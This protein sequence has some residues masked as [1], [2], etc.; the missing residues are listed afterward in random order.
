MKFTM[1]LVKAGFIEKVSLVFL[2]KGHTKNNAGKWFNYLKRGTKGK[3]IWDEK[4]LDEA[5][6]SGNEHLIKL[7][8]VP[9]DRWRDFDSW[10]HEYYME[11]PNEATVPNHIFTFGDEGNPLIMSR[12]TFRFGDKKLHN[13]KASSSSKRHS[14]AFSN[15]ERAEKIRGMYRDLEIIPAPDLSDVKQM[16]MFKKIRSIAPPEPYFYPEPCRAGLDRMKANS[17]LKRNKK[18]DKPTSCTL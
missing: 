2:I 18:R 12:Q 5:Y 7:F 6:T 14:K 1:W 15:L 4:S 9:A 10:L 16:E 13:M 8:R 3:N 17:K 11:L